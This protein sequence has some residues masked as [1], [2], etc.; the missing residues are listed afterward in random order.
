[1]ISWNASVKAVEGGVG[2]IFLLVFL[3]TLSK[4]PILVTLRSATSKLVEDAVEDCLFLTCGTP[5]Q[6]IV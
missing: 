2:H 5:D 1:M 3:D 4:F 6:L